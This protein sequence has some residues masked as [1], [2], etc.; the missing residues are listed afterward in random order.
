L[1][2][3]S[4]RERGGEGRSKGKFHLGIVADSIYGI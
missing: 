2:P 1:P 3:K 4:S